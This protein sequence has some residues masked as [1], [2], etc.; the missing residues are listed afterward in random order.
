MTHHNYTPVEEIEKEEDYWPSEDPEENIA[1]EDGIELEVVGKTVWSDRA[2]KLIQYWDGDSEDS[3]TDWEDL[4]VAG[5]GPQVPDNDEELKTE[6]SWCLNET[7]YEFIFHELPPVQS[8]VTAD[9][10]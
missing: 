5:V 10:P 3:K 7:F 4:S 9:S 1:E 8:I 2:E 6:L